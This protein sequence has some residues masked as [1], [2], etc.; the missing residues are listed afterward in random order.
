MQPLKKIQAQAFKTIY[1][2]IVLTVYSR[3]IT[4]YDLLEF[5]KRQN[6]SHVSVKIN[7]RE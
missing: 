1:I 4:N 2:Y 6:G 5:K 7:K 3:W